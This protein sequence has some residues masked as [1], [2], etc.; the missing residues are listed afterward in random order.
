MSGKVAAIAKDDG[1]RVL[2]FSI[3]ADGTFAIFTAIR[4]CVVV[5]GSCRICSCSWS[6]LGRNT[7]HEI[8]PFLLKLVEDDLK[9]LVGYGV[10][11]FLASVEIER[12]EP[13]LVL[14]VHV[15]LDLLLEVALDGFNIA[16]EVVGFVEFG[17]VVVAER[18]RMRSMMPGG[19][20]K[21]S[22]SSGG[23]LRKLTFGNDDARGILLVW[24]ECPHNGR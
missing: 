11:A 19:M 22:A 17:A 15:V 2:A 21:R 5:V 8:E 16:N 24:K 3:I 9:D 7:L 12:I 10:E 18:Q 14:L 4:V 1:V 23:T 13:F 6:C 20:W